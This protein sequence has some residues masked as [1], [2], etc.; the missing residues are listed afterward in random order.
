MI[1]EAKRKKYEIEWGNE[2]KAKRQSIGDDRD[3]D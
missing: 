1:G 3:I 2:M